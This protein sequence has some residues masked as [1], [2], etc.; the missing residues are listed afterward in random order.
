MI[1]LIKQKLLKQGK[2]ALKVGQKASIFELPNIE[3]KLMSLNILLNKGPVVVT[4][5]RD[6]WCSYCNL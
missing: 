5:Y 1:L 3:G 4:F 6:N 2:E